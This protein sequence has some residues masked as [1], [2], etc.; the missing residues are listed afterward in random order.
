MK[1]VKEKHVLVGADLAGVP[2]KNAVVEHLE[3]KGWTVTDVGVQTAQDD[4][5]EMFHRIGVKVGS[6]IA[7]KEFEKA[8]IFCGSGMGIHL[9]AS[10]V[11]GV[12]CGVVESVPA[13]LRATVGSGLNVLSMGN[14]YVSHRMG[15]EIADVFLNNELGSGFE[16]LTNFYEFHKLALD[17]LAIFDYDEYKANGFEMNKLGEVTIEFK[18]AKK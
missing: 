10:V 7:E 15:T 8:L 2:L 12:V 13:A 3:N 17:E 5:P 9:G 4:N 18:G 1:K 14:Y 11:P 16:W 6:M